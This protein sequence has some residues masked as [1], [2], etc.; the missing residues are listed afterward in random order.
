MILALIA[1]RFAMLATARSDGEG[2]VSFAD[3]QNVLANRP[4]WEL[5]TGSPDGV[6]IKWRE[7]R[8]HGFDDP[9]TYVDCEDTSHL[10]F[11]CAF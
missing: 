6:R 9:Q 2:D 8:H 4:V 3:E 11:A 5:L 7:G 10:L 1:P